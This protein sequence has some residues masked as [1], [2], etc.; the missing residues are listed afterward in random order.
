VFRLPTLRPRSLSARLLLTSLGWSLFALL[1][2]GFVLVSAF[3]ESVEKRFDDTLAVYLSILIGQLADVGD[4]RLSEA[5]PDLDEPRFVLP[6]SGWYWVVVEQKTGD[7]V[8]SSESLAGDMVELP[9]AVSSVPPGRLFSAAVR[10]PTG[11]Q[12]RLAARRVAF[13]NGQWYLVAVTGEAETIAGDTARFTRR[14][15]VYLGLFATVLVAV[16]FVQWRISLRP[17]N[18]LGTELQAVH[19]GRA[20]HVGTRYPLEIMPVAEALNTLIDSNHATLERAR[21]H[22]GNLAHA[23]KTPLSVLMNDAGNEDTPLARSVREQTQTMQ[24]QVRYYL[25]RAQMAAK[26]RMIGAVTDVVPTT[27][28]LH[29]AM[30]RLGER[31]GITVHLDVADRVRFAGEQQDFEEIVGNLVDN[32]LKWATSEVVIDVRPLAAAPGAPKQ[33]Q[34]SI[35]DDGPGL[36]E[37]AR[38]EAL[39]RGKRLDQSKPGSGLGLSIVAELVSLYGGRFHLDRADAGG[40]RAVVVLPRA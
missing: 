38:S 16:V 8:V 39:S 28:R 36:S 32:A 7:V 14:L 31:R 40:L 30:A 24:R 22:V 9:A 15:V 33:F 17:L 20:R 12:L 23:L 3:R 13:D 10:G 4:Q 37:A 35:D 11:T 19:E 21:Q 18:Q 27:E 26:E 2:T 25:E 29:R 6:L 34:V 5:T 1:A